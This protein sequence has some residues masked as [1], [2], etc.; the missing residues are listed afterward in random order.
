M[1]GSSAAPLR[2]L[3]VGEVLDGAVRLARRNA[4]S[5]LIVSVPYAIVATLA[6]ALL[7]YGT[8][9]SQDATTLVAIGG[10]I[11][12]A[13]LGAVLTG[14]LAP[15]F[16]ADLLGDRITIGKSLRRVGGRAGLLFML[17]LAV[18]ISE[19]AGLVACIVGGVWLWGIWA[20][21]APAF[22]LERLGI[23]AALAR[24]RAL[25]SGTFWRVWGIRALGWFVV[26]VLMQLI[27]LP[28]LALAAKLTHVDLLDSNPH[29]TNAAL[30][31]AIVSAGQLIAAALLAPV[32]SAIEVLLYTDLRMR[33]EGM[34]IVL[35]LGADPASTAAGPAPVSAW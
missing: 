9:N 4:R 32:S 26:Y 2:P 20:V 8:I 33:K 28:F 1:I 6:G 22:A 29:T 23:R 3:G 7:Q 18:A 19:G 25:V 30:Y 15:L 16:S 10:L 31:V 27:E 35:G 12:T 13:G 24:S 17:G 11:I 5:V 21:A 14:L 34:D